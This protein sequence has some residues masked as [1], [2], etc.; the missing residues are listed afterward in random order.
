MDKDNWVRSSVTYLT[1]FIYSGRREYQ[2]YDSLVALLLIEFIK[3]RSNICNCANSYNFITHTTY[4]NMR[5][6]GLIEYITPIAL[7]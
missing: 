6:G 4:K 2:R 3:V 1:N 5:E 7:L